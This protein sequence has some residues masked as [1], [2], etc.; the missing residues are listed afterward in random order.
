MDRNQGMTESMARKILGKIPT[1][2]QREAIPAAAVLKDA[3][4]SRPQ[5]MARDTLPGVPAD[6]ASEIEEMAA[7]W[8]ARLD[9]EAATDDDRAA[10]AAW[11][12]ASEE[13]RQAVAKLGALFGE[14]DKLRR[15]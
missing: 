10:F 15:R 11:C 9:N 3:A 5:I 1:F 12:D 13:H 7:L 4:T 6:R 14:M 2:G 8:I